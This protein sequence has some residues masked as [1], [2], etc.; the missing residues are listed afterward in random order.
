MKKLSCY[1]GLL[2][3]TLWLAACKSDT[4]L[5]PETTVGDGEQVLEITVDGDFYA[6]SRSTAESVGYKLV[7][8]Q[9]I[10]HIEHLYA[11]IFNGG[12]MDATCVYVTEI[13]WE[14]NSQQGSAS[15]TYRLKE[16]NLPQYVTDGKP[17]DMQ[18]L[19]VA[20]DNN[21]DTYNFPYGEVANH[22]DNTNQEGNNP[23][24]GQPLSGVKMKL[25]EAAAGTTTSDADKAFKMANT[26]VFSGCTSFRAD[27]QIIKVSL[28]RCV[29][30]VLCYL[31]DIPY[32]V[33]TGTE[34]NNKISSIE[35]QLGNSLK[36]N[37]EYASF[38]DGAKFGSVSS[39][40]SESSDN[41]VIASVNISEYI[42]GKGTTNGTLDVQESDQSLTD[43]NTQR[44]YVPAMDNG[45]VKTKENTILFGAYLLPIENAATDDNTTNATLKLLL[46]SNGGEQ[47]AFIVKNAVTSVPGEPDASGSPTTITEPAYAY[48]LKANRLYSIGSKP[49]ATDTDVDQPASLKG[50][51][52][53]LNVIDWTDGNKE[54]QN[55]V[56]FPVYSLKS[57]ISADWDIQYENYIFD[58]MSETRTVYI[59]PS[60]EDAQS[61]NFKVQ[62]VYSPEF[63]NNPWVKFRFIDEETGKPFDGYDDWYTTIDNI[64][65]E[66]NG[67]ARMALEV[68]LNDYVKE[69][70]ILGNS[71]ITDK[72]DALLK[73]LRTANLQLVNPSNAE[74]LSSVP[75]QQ[76]NAITVKFDYDKKSYTVG[77]S[78][79]DLWDTMADNG[80]AKGE[81]RYD[82]W[83]FPGIVIPWY[84]YGTTYDSNVDGEVNSDA[85][86]K[87]NHSDYTTSVL[88]YARVKT[89]D[90]ELGDG[91]HWYLPAREELGAFFNNVVKE[92]GSY[93]V[94][95]LIEVVNVHHDAFYWTSSSDGG[96][97]GLNSYVMKDTDSKPSGMRRKQS[98]YCR[99]ARKFN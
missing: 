20:V 46:K 13:P 82:T 4:P 53:E 62:V 38:Y 90:D 95:N 35:L 21:T 92:I 25:A 63:E 23:I 76:F 57:T 2:M 54:G 85:A 58:C 14:Q 96:D 99:Q 64:P 50:K 66:L 41:K 34:D 86:E 75:I 68:R 28:Q 16:A 17:S 87:I 94:N 1:I 32:Y 5:E 39:D 60:E 97:N 67:K 42:Y 40:N 88:Y 9:A 49:F 27:D 74:V 3:A 7:S 44:L 93:N 71:S 24:I 19:V 65:E 37:T 51:E 47:T 6:S 77:F 18:V 43:K 26:E 78:R 73:D 80:V 91:R 36:L 12:D 84:I 81:G 31:T 72:K 89:V 45:V 56:N 29:A 15:L 59:Y 83:G 55:N 98:A 61:L 69:N 33:G 30:G 52:V 11:Y 79:V 10:Q 48:S 22:A 70:D 8:S